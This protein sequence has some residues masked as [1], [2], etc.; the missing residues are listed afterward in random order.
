MSQ[1]VPIFGPKKG[2]R[3]SGNVLT[4]G[5][6]HPYGVAS[7]RAKKDVHDQKTRAGARRRLAKLSELTGRSTKKG[8]PPFWP[9]EGRGNLQPGG[10]LQGLGAERPKE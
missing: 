8:A 3:V 4:P 2:I 1:I 7:V 5:V 6:L 9:Y 10:G